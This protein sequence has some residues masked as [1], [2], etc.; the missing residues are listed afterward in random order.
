MTIWRSFSD[1][2][3]NIVTDY[4]VLKF[5]LLHF[6]QVLHPKKKPLEPQAFGNVLGFCKYDALYMW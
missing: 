1:K 3:N 6:G 2:R 4:F 5:Y